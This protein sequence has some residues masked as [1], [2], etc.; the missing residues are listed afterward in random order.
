MICKRL[1]VDVSERHYLR[2]REAQQLFRNIAKK[3]R[4][5]HFP[6]N[7]AKVEVVKLDNEEQI[8][9]VDGQPLFFKSEEFLPTLLNDYVLKR[10]PKI[11]V[12]V[13]AIPHICNGADIMAPGI[14]DVEGEFKAGDLAVIIDER[15]SKRIALG[16]ALF[17]VEETRVKKRGKVASNVHYVNDSY[18]K[19]CKQLVY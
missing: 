7:K 2:K 17:S 1:R 13:G 9:I 11:V 19:T 14:V 4:F 16:R 18:W 12:D 5:D 10:L 15:F 8:F 3:M 6:F